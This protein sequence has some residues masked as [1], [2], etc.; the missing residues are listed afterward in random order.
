MLSGTPLIRTPSRRTPPGGI[1]CVTF[2]V[3][4]SVSPSRWYTVCHITGGIQCVTF[5][6][7]YSVLPSQV[8]GALVY[9][10]GELQFLNNSGGDESALHMLSFAQIV[11]SRGLFINFEGNT[12]RSVVRCPTSDMDRSSEIRTPH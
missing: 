10:S 5:Q 3:V 8:V 12:G 9:L 11:L 2:Q 1:Q 7:V 4:Y 6:V